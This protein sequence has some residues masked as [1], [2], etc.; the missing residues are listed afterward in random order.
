M[1]MRRILEIISLAG[2]LLMVWM[3]GETLYGPGRLPAR[4]PI[5]FDVAGNPNAWG[6][7]WTL[8]GIPVTALLI[9]VLMTVVARYPA[10]F[11]FPVRVTPATR[12]RLEAL[13]LQMI[14]WLKTE[15]VCLFAW[16]QA[17]TIGV[18]RHGHGGLSPFFMPVVLAAVFVTVVSYVIAMRRVGRR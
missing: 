8:L 11:N 3:T 15:V 1:S 17:V 13:A 4:I 10:A 2:M 6:S 18:A 9:Y 16:I 7:R 14:S 12:P 5:H